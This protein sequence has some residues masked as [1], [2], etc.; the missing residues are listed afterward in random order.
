MNTVTS[1]E[2]A[3]ELR[4]IGVN[5]KAGF[6]YVWN[7]LI[8]DYETYTGL[9]KNEPKALKKLIKI[10]KYNNGSD[11]YVIKYE[12]FSDEPLHY[13]LLPSLYV[14]KVA[15]H[16]LEEL[17]KLNAENITIDYK[18]NNYADYVADKYIEN[19]T[20]IKGVFGFASGL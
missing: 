7:Y 4:D 6:Y 5:Q 11:K 12:K 13:S 17:I 14:D 8:V 19:L 20:E 1:I 3:L 9:Y 16:S 15:A 10:G 2:R 18:A